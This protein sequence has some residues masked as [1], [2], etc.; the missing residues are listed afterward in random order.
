M[1][2][3]Y[4]LYT[5]NSLNVKSSLISLTPAHI[6]V[7]YQPKESDINFICANIVGGNGFFL[8]DFYEE[9]KAVKKLR[10]EKLGG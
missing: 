3:P 2:A 4:N 7:L 1:E 9:K 6:L 8:F 10:Q 5:F